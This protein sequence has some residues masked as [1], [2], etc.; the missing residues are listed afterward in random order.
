M[1]VFVVVVAVLPSSFSH[2][3]QLRAQNCWVGRDGNEALGFALAL[4]CVALPFVR[5][6]SYAGAANNAG[7]PTSKITK[8]ND[9]NPQDLQDAPTRCR[10]FKTLQKAVR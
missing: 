1:I 7:K 3:L 2:V 5:T 6:S 10:C 8:L 4:R 9:A